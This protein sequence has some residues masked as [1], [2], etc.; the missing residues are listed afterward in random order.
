MTPCPT[1]GAT[2]AEGASWCTQ[3]Y[4]SLTAPVAEPEAPRGPDGPHGADGP[5]G[6]DGSHGAG[7]P[8]QRPPASE[9]APDTG[10]RRGPD[11][12][13]WICVACETANPM[14]RSTCAVCGIPFTA[15][16]AVAE[17]RAPVDW[18]AARTASVLL[19]GLGH[20]RADR[21]ATGWAR[22]VLF[23]VWALGGLL[24]LGGAGTAGLPVAAPLLLGAVVIHLLT[25]VDLRNLEHGGA[26]LLAGRTLLWL[27]VG[28]TLLVVVGA[29]LAFGGAATGGLPN[30]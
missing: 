9:P 4:A 8:A 19:P 17:R 13:E 3:C 20:I 24:I 18:A 14:E 26:E 16:F 1:C 23:A 21:P 5:H 10:L 25:Q 27:V 15:R 29:V 2:N 12:L 22:I 30:P 28:V 11:G 6:T 7:D